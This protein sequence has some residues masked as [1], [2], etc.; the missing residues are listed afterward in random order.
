MKMLN[1]VASV[2]LFAATLFVSAA[3]MFLLQPMFGK[4]LL[5]LL[6]GSP[7]VWNTCMVFYQT[8]LFLGYSYAHGVS[9]R[10]NARHQALLHGSLVLASLAALPVALPAE[11]SPPAGNDP[12]FWLLWTLLAAIGLPFF[13]VST[14]APLLQKWFSRIGHHT[15]DDPY[16]LY[17][18][19]NAG[20]LLALLSYPFLIEPNIGLDWQKLDWSIGYAGL[21]LLI[22]VCGGVLLV[23]GHTSTS[24]QQPA[25]AQKLSLHTQLHWL[26]LAFVPSSL[27]LGLTNFISTDIASV[28]LLWIIPLTVYLTTFIAAFS[29]WN[30]RLLPAMTTAQ[31][32]FL[33]PFI[34]YAFVNPAD[35]PY[36]AYLVLHVMAFFFAVM[37]CHGQLAKLRPATEH[38]TRYYLI[39]SFAGML[40]GMFNT[41]AAPFLFNGIYEYPIMVTVALMLRPA[42]KAGYGLMLPQIGL[43]LLL[44]VAGLLFY[45]TINDATDYFD[46]IALTLMLLA[47]ATFLLRSRPIAYAGLAGVIIGLAMNVHT[48]SAHTL[49]QK[50]TFF[51]VSSVRE[52]S[53]ETDQGQPESYHELFHGTTK[54]GAQ[55]LTEDFAKT[56]LTYYSRPGPMGQLFREFDANN[57]GW[58]IGIVGLGA[59]ALVCYA[60]PEQQWLIYELDPLVVDIAKN[61]AYFSYLSRCAPKAEVI[62]GDARLSL[63]REP[64]G[65]FDLLM[66]DAFSS[67]AIPTHLLTQEALQLYFNK[68]KP[69]GILALH[70]TNR[71]LAVKKVLSILSE[72]LQLASLIQEYTPQ[73]DIPLVVATDWVVMA[74]HPDTLKRLR[75]SRLG[76]WQKMPLYFDMAPWTD[77]FTNIIGIWKSS[78]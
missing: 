50:R 76:S 59:G 15:S 45:N 57:A 32:I 30:N 58:T 55:R 11:L 73:Q 41:F 36:W 9:T 35:L 28:P 61:P 74:K 78:S 7:A 67:D 16:Y 60:K 2:L 75:E 37:V 54:H 24:A 26:L 25:E 5:P 29:H 40:G 1:P 27:L 48:L 23:S 51:G 47:C 43:P 39:M 62:I 71:H 22:L 17:A 66:V 46:A 12:T 21:C 3:L 20:S 42:G 72:K 56:P 6:G 44:L 53:L 65:K 8:I 10:L 70:V 38:L 49:L 63:L 64:A 19:S 77:D 4:L 68:L 34:A 31:S 69:D 13:V 33:I 18:A 14:T 52:S